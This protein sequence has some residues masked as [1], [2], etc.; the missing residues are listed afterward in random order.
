MMD[1]AMPRKILS[2]TVTSGTIKLQVVVPEDTFRRLKVV[3][4]ANGKTVRD[5]ITELVQANLPP[6][7]ELL[8]K[9]QN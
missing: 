8:L 5:V 7:P 1:L 9:K 2:H 3:A 4:A 6:V